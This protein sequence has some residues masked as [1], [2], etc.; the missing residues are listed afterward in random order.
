MEP[1]LGWGSYRAFGGLAAMVLGRLPALSV[2]NRDVLYHR[3]RGRAFAWT[4]LVP[5]FNDGAATMPHECAA[6]A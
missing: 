4:Q 1:L 5:A 6:S 3:H 2:Q